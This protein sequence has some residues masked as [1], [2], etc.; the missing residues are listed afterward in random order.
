MMRATI[1]GGIPICAAVLAA[2]PL[3][4]FAQ[5]DQAPAAAAQ[6]DDQGQE[7]VITGSRIPAPNLTAVSPVT[8]IN[9]AEIR[10]QGVTRTEDLINS[11]PQS[12]AAQGSNLSNGASGTATVNLRNLGANRTV[13]LINGCRLMPGDNLSPFPDLNFIPS[14]LIKRV[15]VLTGGASSTYGADAV[16]GVVNFI[17]DNT[18][19]GVR[20][21]AQ[22]S[23][24]MH[25]NREDGPIRLANE[26]RG[27]RPPS[28]LS[29]SFCLRR[30]SPAAAPWP[31]WE[32]TI[33]CRSAL[34]HGRAG[35][36]GGR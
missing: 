24:F 19:T 3:P 34:G 13:V 23:A 25:D 21:D 32:A 5:D 4:A 15:D 22:V 33:D 12:F 16:G 9:S 10:L 1:R 35:W 18:F 2:M 30:A 31:G 14:Q 7:V 28:G 8:V 17:M 20:L 6:P 29:P 27:F 26:L 36:P 11:L